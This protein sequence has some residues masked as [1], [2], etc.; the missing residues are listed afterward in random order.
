VPEVP[1]VAITGLGPV[2]P[3]GIGVGEFWDSLKAGKSGAGKLERFPAE[4]YTSQVSAE[5][6]DFNPG[7]FMTP[8]QERR[9]QTFTQFAFAAATLA[10][11]DAALEPSNADPARTGIVVG[12]GIGGI[13]FFEAEH[14]VLLEKGPRRVSPEL[15]GGM[16]PNAASGSLAI[17][18]GFM[19]PNECTVTACASG[20]H[21]IAR[22][23]E[24]IRTGQADVMLA[25]GSEAAITPLAVASFCSARALTKR[26]DE[27]E[28]ASR[29]FDA[30]RDGFVVGE[31]AC[32]LV[33]ERWDLA[34]AR[35]ARI[36]GEILGYGLSADAYHMVAPHPEGAGAAAA[37]TS[38]LSQAGV[39]SD[40]VG[41]I[42]AHATSTNLGDA[43]EAAAIKKI[44]GNN[45]PPTS[46][47]KSM[48]GHMIGAAGSTELAA[49]I[50]AIEDQILPPTINYEF[51]DPACDIDVVPNEA[52]PHRFELGMSNSFGFG[53]HNV[54][55]LVSG[56]S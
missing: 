54:S 27:P 30:E 20:G 49:T 53:G 12:T 37:M 40:E 14:K 7:D 48:T 13:A 26:N 31:G 34:V 1:R 50:L 47:T 46:G 22:A 5:V 43:A 15:V 41:Y 33:L 56:G 21:A 29:P 19:G 39:T 45:P 35:G 18:F 24:L 28:K 11:A 36:R 38:A 51:P 44:F 55:I 2:T 52:R 3:I 23:C 32:V 25:G 10:L 6:R 9:F 42:N 8:K 4:G 17:E 16:I